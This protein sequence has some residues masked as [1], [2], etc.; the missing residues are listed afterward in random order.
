MREQGLKNDFHIFFNFQFIRSFTSIASVLDELACFF[1]ENF[2]TGPWFQTQTKI[3]SKNF[4]KILFYFF[5]SGFLLQTLRIHRT[6]GKGRGLSLFFFTASTCSETLR[7]LL[8]VLHLRWRHS[9]INH[10]I[11]IEGNGFFCHIH[12]AH[13]LSPLKFLPKISTKNISTTK[14][15]VLTWKKYKFFKEKKFSHLPRK[16]N[17]PP[18]ERISN[19]L[20]KKQFSK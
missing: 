16:T 10:G 19:N 20:R 7:N 2:F 1:L 18:K 14:F 9:I 15:L 8:A 5:S 13:L 17:S 12:L 3:R 6:A 4:T 11:W